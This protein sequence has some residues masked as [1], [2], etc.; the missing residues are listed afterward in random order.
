[1]GVSEREGQLK[2]EYSEWYPTLKV[3]VWYPVVWLTQTV[4]QQLRSSE[5]RWDPDGRVPSDQHFTFR[6]GPLEPRPEGPGHER[7]TAQ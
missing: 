6:G 1:V 7:R 5:P 3:G 4:L 2:P